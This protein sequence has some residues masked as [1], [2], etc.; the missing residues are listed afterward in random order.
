MPL[1]SVTS[2]G[3]YS[4]DQTCTANG[5]GVT[6]KTTQIGGLSRTVVKFTAAS[7]TWT[8][9]GATGAG[10]SLKVIDL[11]LGAVNIAAAYLNI[12]AVTAADAPL[13]AGT[14]SLQ[15]SMGTTAAATDNF[16]LT[17]TEANVVAAGSAITLS[18]G[19]FS[20]NSPAVNGAALCLDGTSTAVD[21]Y[22][23]AT[24]NAT[25]STGN[26]TVTVTGFA[27]IWWANMGGLTTAS[28]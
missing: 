18:S 17:T 9:N 26:G 24:A 25:N 16:T 28:V 14:S 4:I 27:V 7:L 5:T 21:I 23:N 10:G 19:A 20:G 13:Q 11:P 15:F 12:T 2:R 1:P 6:L 3:S 8:D 22:L